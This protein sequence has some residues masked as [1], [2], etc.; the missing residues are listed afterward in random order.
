MIN[1][2][3]I[4][5]IASIQGMEIQLGGGVR[6]ES[7]IDRL[8]SINISYIIVGSIAIQSPETLNLWIEKYGAQQ[9]CVALDIKDNQLAF[10][11]WQELQNLQL[12]DVIQNLISLGI[13][14]F[15]ST[16]IRRDGTLAGPNTELYTSLVQQFPKVTWLASGGVRSIEDVQNLKA[17]GVAGAIIGKALYEGTI[18]LDQLLSIFPGK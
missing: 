15:L 10:A 12:T 3:S 16:D 8:R 9:F 7:D 4:E 5:K 14:R 13:S 1:W 17:K 18:K 2:S 6:T 11:G